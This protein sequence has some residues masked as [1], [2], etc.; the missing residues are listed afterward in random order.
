MGQAF[1]TRQNW[2]LRE[3]PKRIFFCCSF[4]IFVLM[5]ACQAHNTHAVAPSATP[6]IA[7]GDQTENPYE[8]PSA[9]TEH[10]KTRNIFNV[11]LLFDCAI[12]AVV[13]FFCVGFFSVLWFFSDFLMSSAIDTKA[14][15]SWHRPG[16]RQTAARIL[17]FSH[18]CN[19]VVLLYICKSII[20][21]I[22]SHSI[23]SNEVETIHRNEDAYETH[24][25]HRERK[26]RI[27]WTRYTYYSQLH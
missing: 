1:V 16:S 2:K 11:L 9:H 18:I 3:M 20:Y 24:W 5:S 15:C 4:S 19:N 23:Q 14:Y 7:E 13:L 17:F 22:Q 12:L 27:E 8:C 10:T 26:K 6:Y 25:K 21:S